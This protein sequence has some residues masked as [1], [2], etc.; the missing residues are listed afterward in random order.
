MHRGFLFHSALMISDVSL[1]VRKSTQR[2]RRSKNKSEQEQQR[3]E[4]GIIPRAQTLMHTF[5]PNDR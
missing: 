2:P 5:N 3:E 1:N 4:T